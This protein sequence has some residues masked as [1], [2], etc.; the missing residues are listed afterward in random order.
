[1]EMQCRIVV[2]AFGFS[3]TCLLV[4]RGLGNGYSFGYAALSFLLTDFQ[5]LSRFQGTKQ[6]TDSA[7]S[8]KKYKLSRQDVQ[9]LRARL[10]RVLRSAIGKVH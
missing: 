6:T 5:T 4:I 1:M 8:K 2:T 7:T 3:F 9:R 10:N